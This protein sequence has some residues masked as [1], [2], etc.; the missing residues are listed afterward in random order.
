VTPVRSITAWAVEPKVGV[1]VRTEAVAALT[2]INVNGS[3]I[4]TKCGH[5]FDDYRAAN[6]L[7]VNGERALAC[8]ECGSKSGRS[9]AVSASDS[10]TAVDAITGLLLT[11]ADLRPWEEKW[12]KLLDALEELRELY[13]DGRKGESSTRIER[14]FDDFFTTCFH[15]SDWL[16]HDEAIPRTELNRYMGSEQAL[17]IARAFSNSDKHDTRSNG[18]T[19]RIREVELAGAVRVGIEENWSTPAAQSYDALAIAESAVE[20]WRRYLLSKGLTPPA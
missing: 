6:A 17:D 12:L 10:A 2:L 14:R 8:P 9:I 1:I 15:L 20:A 5:V 7:D 3:I 18:S 11:K 16:E 13:A 19:V 4:C